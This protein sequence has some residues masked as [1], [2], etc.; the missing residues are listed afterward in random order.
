MLSGS[1]LRW[2]LHNRPSLDILDGIFYP[3]YPKIV[4]GEGTEEEKKQCIF[5]SIVLNQNR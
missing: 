3:N 2:D 1:T 4:K 5:G